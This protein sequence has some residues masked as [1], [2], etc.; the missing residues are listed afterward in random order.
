MET[1]FRTKKAL[2]MHKYTYLL[3]R[4]DQEPLHI[5]CRARQ[6]ACVFVTYKKSPETQDRS[7]K[8]KY[9][10]RLW[11]TPPPSKIQG[12]NFFQCKTLF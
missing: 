6:L 12:K 9:T 4:K 5:I 11:G 10:T 3:I 8:A 1:Y 7:L 2:K